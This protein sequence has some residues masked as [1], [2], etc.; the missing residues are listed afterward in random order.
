MLDEEW[1]NKKQEILRK[2]NNAM[3]YESFYEQ[4]IQP[5]VTAV[6]GKKT[7]AHVGKHG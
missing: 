7:T 5:Y 1:N 2:I 3:T 6:I 4:V